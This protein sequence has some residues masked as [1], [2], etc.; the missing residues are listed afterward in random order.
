MDPDM[1]ASMANI[2][3][4]IYLASVDLQ[5]KTAGAHNSHET[6]AQSRRGPW[7]W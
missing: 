3:M 7:W 6:S 4:M 1:S 5:A 2:H